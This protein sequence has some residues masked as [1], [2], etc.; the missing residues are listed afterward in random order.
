MQ[1]Q[2]I[3]TGESVTSF[4]WIAESPRP[5][6][7]N[8]TRVM[9][10]RKEPTRDGSYAEFFIVRNKNLKKIEGDIL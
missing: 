1:Y 4:P 3:S 2:I 9:R 7:H 10:S 6:G 5:W 8:Y